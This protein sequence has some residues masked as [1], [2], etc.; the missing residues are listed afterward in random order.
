VTWTITV[1]DR[2]WNANERVHWSVRAQRTTDWRTL[3]W[4]K[5]REARIPALPAAYIDVHVTHPARYMPPDPGNAYPAVK[6]L[7]DGLVDARVIPDDGPQHL[8]RLTFVAPTEGEA[9]AI[10]LV[11]RPAEPGPAPSVP[12]KR[13]RSD[14]PRP[15]R[16]RAV[17][18]VSPN[19]GAGTPIRPRSV[20]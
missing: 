12:R 10:S 20:P 6:A 9:W 2:P 3:G 14:S 15:K 4:A 8:R 1:P 5:A 19:S 11:V 7:I 13:A 18:G 17:A 16:P